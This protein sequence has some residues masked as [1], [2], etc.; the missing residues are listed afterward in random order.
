M[1]IDEDFNL[2]LIEVNMSP[3]LVADQ[4]T[5]EHKYSFENVLYNLFSLI[6][7]GTIYE[8]NSFKIPNGFFQMV[9]NPDSMSVLPE[10]CL[11][12]KC[13]DCKNE[14]CERCWK[15]LDTTAK[16]EL[17]QAYGEQMNIGNFERLFPPNEEFMKATSDEFW[18]QLLE[19]NRLHVK[20]FVE[21][22]K[23]NKRFC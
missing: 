3:N 6:G 15:C 10:T 2:F 11:S 20:W 5:I 7:V 18:N 13:I 12:S 21:M 8:K 14:G 19:R 23:N 9:A 16:Y 17:I 22:C 4:N 1:L